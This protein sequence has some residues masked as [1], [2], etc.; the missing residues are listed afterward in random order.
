MK[1]RCTLVLLA[2]LTSCAYPLAV[3]E[4]TASLESRSAIP[5]TVPN[6][7][8]PNPC[9]SFEGSYR[10][11]CDEQG[12]TGVT[13]NSMTS[14]VESMAVLCGA[15]SESVEDAKTG[16]PELEEDSDPIEF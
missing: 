2:L 6:P 7:D 4:R 10:D 13:A 15:S 11:R 9:C 12:T 14:I 5:N 3:E 1:D 8:C 16:E